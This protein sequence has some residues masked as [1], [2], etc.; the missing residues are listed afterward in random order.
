MRKCE[1]CQCRIDAVARADARFCSTRCRVA[2]HRSRQQRAALPTALTDR[3]AWVRRVGKRPVRLDGSPASSTTPSTWSTY[4]DALAATAGDG[5][6][7][8]LGAGLAC[9]DLDHCLDA[10]SLAPWAADVLAAIDDPLWVER[11]MSGTGLH[12][13]VNAA[14]APGHRRDGVEFYSRHR[15]IAVTGDHY[16]P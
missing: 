7:V 10:E 6:G 9:W 8:M 1:K 16:E 2:A 15:F 12:V 4:A 14:E 5:V 3:T 11:S 13:F